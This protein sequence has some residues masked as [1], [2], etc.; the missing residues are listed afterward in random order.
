MSQN[1][2]SIWWNELLTRD[3]DKSCRYYRDMCGWRFETVPMSGGE[4]AP[5]LLAYLGD[6]IV[7]GIIDMQGHAH[8][9]DV[10]EGWMTYIAVDDLQRAIRQTKDAGG[11]VL[12]DAFEV[13]GAGLIATIRDPLGCMIGLIVPPA[14]G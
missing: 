13:P 14:D 2:G 11:K 7:G 8:F 6:K 9:D 10:A 12:R 5:Y 4:G 1:H 3:V